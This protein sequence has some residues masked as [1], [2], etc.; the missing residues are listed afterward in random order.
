MMKCRRL[1][2]T[3]GGKRALQ[4]MQARGYRRDQMRGMLQCGGKLLLNGG[5]E[6]NK[7]G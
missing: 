3:C 2:K 4:G 6:G 1:E 5:K 7:N